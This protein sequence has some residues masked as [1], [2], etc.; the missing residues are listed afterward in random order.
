MPLRKQYDW[1][2]VKGFSHAMVRHLSQ[3]LPQLFVAKSGPKNRIGKIFV[4]YLRNGFGATTAAA[5]SARA[6]PGLGVS[7][8]ISWEELPQLSSG[9]QWTI[10]NVADRLDVGNAPL[11]AATPQALAGP[12]NALGC[13]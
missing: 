12:M 7:V 4:D 5:W 9:A 3:T 8:P 1:D 11:D 6:R 10:T 2:T 13:R